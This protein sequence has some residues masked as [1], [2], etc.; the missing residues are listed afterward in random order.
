MM[1]DREL[2]DEVMD[3]FD[4]EKVSVAMEALGWEWVALDAVPD[5]YHLRKCARSLLERVIKDNLT[6]STG[7]FTAQY[8][9]EE[10]TLRFYVDEVFVQRT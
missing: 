3:N 2:I 4:F 1:T 6:I 10:L 5:K 7:G 9:G 8:D